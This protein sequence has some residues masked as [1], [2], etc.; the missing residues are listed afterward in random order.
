MRNI[1]RGMKGTN[2]MKVSDNEVWT[3]ADWIVVYSAW[4][5]CFDA[6]VDNLPERDWDRLVALVRQICDKLEHVPRK[7]AEWEK[8]LAETIIDS[9][10]TG[11]AK[12]DRSIQ[13]HGRY[14][15]EALGWIVDATRSVPWFCVC[16]DDQALER[17]DDEFL[18]LLVDDE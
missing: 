6:G 1:F 3:I 2:Q 7:S 16:L 17:R 4:D 10:D 11:V 5:S 14:W 9:T 18:Q 8:R 12:T 13:Q 15:R